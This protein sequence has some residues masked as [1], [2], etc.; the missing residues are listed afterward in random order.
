MN[1]LSIYALK[2]GIPETE[3]TGR[4]R[5]QRIAL[6]RQS[7]WYHLWKRGHKVTSIAKMFNRNAHSTVISGI[8]TVKDLIDTKDERITKYLELLEPP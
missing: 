7:Y 8:N 1:S 5:K 4:S 2:T 3:L 6:A